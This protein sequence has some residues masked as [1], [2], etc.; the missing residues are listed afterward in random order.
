MLLALAKLSLGGAGATILN[1]W[2]LDLPPPGGKFETMMS[3]VLPKGPSRFAGR[4]AWR[5]VGSGQAP[6]GAATVIPFCAPL[7]KTLAE[8]EKPVPLI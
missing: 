1:G 4:V 6:V 5:H 3:F 8:A 2:T 7:N